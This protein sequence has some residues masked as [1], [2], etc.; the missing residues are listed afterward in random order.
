MPPEHVLEQ[1]G[2]ATAVA[3][4]AVRDRVLGRPAGYLDGLRAVSVGIAA[5]QS[6]VTGLPVTI[7]DLDLGVSLEAD[8]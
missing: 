8:R 7:G 6:L 4:D 3:A 2:V 1:D 5:N